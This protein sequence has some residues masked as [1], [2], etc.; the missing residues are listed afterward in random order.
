MKAINSEYEKEIG[1][2]EITRN[3]GLG[4]VVS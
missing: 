4:V 3:V 1:I 2:M